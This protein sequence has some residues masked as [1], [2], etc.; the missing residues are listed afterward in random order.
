MF[1]LESLAFDY[2]QLTSGRLM[3]RFEALEKDRDEVQRK[4]DLHL[5][6]VKARALEQADLIAETVR[7]IARADAAERSGTT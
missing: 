6:E 4:L 1:E 3:T 5:P 7:M 2:E